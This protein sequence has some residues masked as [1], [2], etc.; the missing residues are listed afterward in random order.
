[1]SITYG[2]R[3]RQG[4]EAIYFT[5]LEGG[6]FVPFDDWAGLKARLENGL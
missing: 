5:R 6:R 3:D 4:L 2:P 1:M